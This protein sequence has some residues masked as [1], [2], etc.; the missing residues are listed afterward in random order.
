M[1]E[2]SVQPV[3][4]AL[5]ASINISYFLI[6]ELG[7]NEK[8]TIYFMKLDASRMGLFGEAD[9]KLPKVCYAGPERAWKVTQWVEVTVVGQVP[10]QGANDD[11]T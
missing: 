9:I 2:D 4:R 10:N 7:S 8:P 1:L 3:Q 11:G 6:Y 5:R